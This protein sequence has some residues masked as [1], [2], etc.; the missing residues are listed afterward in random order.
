[1]DNVDYILSSEGSKIFKLEL[2]NINFAL[3]L[4]KVEISISLKNDLK[5]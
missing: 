2:E 5:I 3:L 1:M 4:K